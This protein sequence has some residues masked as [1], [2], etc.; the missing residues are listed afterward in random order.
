M[1]IF[2]MCYCYTHFR[3]YTYLTFVATVVQYKLHS[4]TTFTRYITLTHCLGFCFPMTDVLVSFLVDLTRVNLQIQMALNQNTHQDLPVQHN[5]VQT[6]RKSLKTWYIYS[7]AVPK[8]IFEVLA[9]TV[10]CYIML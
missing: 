10:F 8:N 4:L 3:I 2:C 6:T 9:L 7:R 1:T 5:T